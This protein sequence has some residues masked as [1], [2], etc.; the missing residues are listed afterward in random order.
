M[1]RRAA[2]PL[3]PEPTLEDLLR[4]REAEELLPKLEGES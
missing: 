4:Q 1:E 2:D 3:A